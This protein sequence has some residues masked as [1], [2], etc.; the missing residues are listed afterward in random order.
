MFEDD[1]FL[2]PSRPLTTRYLAEFFLACHCSI[3]PKKVTCKKKKR[4]TKV[5]TLIKF[6]LVFNTDYT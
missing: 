1:Q 4:D 6:W 2:H 5:F 3:L